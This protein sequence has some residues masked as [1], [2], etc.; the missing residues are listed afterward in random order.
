MNNMKK[1]LLLILLILLTSLSIYKGFIY[2]QEFQSLTPP[3]DYYLFRGVGEAVS[4]QRISN[5]YS[6]EGTAQVISHMVDRASRSGSALEKNAVKVFEMDKTNTL[7]PTASPL[8]YAAVGILSTNSFDRD[9]LVFNIIM[10]ASYLLSLLVLSKML[11]LSAI[12]TAIVMLYFTALFNPY[13]VDTGSVNINQIQLLLITSIIL[14][15]VYQK[16]FW[17]G[18]A[19]AGSVMLKLNVMDLFLVVL[20]YAIVRYN[21][22]QLCRFSVGGVSA[23][24]LSIIAGSLYFN[25]KFIWVKFIESIPKTLAIMSLHFELENL[26]LISLL[27]YIT[28]IDFTVLLKILFY[29]PLLYMVVSAIY[30]RKN[31]SCPGFAHGHRL[32]AKIINSATNHEPVLEAFMVTGA[33]ISI[34]LLSSGVVWMHYY[35]LNI[36]LILLIIRLITAADLNGYFK[37]GL[38]L[39]IMGAHSY[40]MTLFAGP[41][42]RSIALNVSTVI[43]LAVCYALWS[44]MQVKHGHEPSFSAGTG[45]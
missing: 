21:A 40:F 29:V 11:Q 19:L 9:V 4:S 44:S 28:S 36:P 45:F 10:L 15:L 12:W 3:C 22:K 17:C 25:D 6:D 18:F 37:Y 42:S 43:M 2:Q 31:D 16:T 35:I 26:G 24:I 20:C 33:G 13:L 32:S 41:V 39:T 7:R 1:K 8:L 23:A 5:I 14:S 30:C 38:I 27:K 34:M